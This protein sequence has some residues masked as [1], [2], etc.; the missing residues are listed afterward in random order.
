VM[1]LITISGCQNPKDNC[2]RGMT[3]SSKVMEW[4]TSEIVNDANVI[5]HHDCRAI[6]NWG[7]FAT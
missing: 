4:T 2:A 3:L 7:Y 5:T 1:N 6:S